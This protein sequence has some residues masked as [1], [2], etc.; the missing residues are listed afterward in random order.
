MSTKLLFKLMAVAAVGVLLSVSHT[1]AQTCTGTIITPSGEVTNTGD[2]MG[3]AYTDTASSNNTREAFNERLSG[4]FSRL[5][6]QWTFSSVPAGNVSIIREG[7]RLVTPDADNFKFQAGYDY[8]D[9]NGIHMI[10]GSFCTINSDTEGSSKCS[11][12][13]TI[14]TATWTVTVIDT[15]TTSGTDLTA[16]SIDYLALCVE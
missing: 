4:G 6:H 16:L 13:S 10:F 12:G 2:R 7:Y 11:L 1:S 9:G 8:N 5:N 14:D 15:V 3:G